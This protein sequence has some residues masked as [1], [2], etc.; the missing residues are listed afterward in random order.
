MDYSMTGCSGGRYPWQGLF[1]EQ[2]CGKWGWHVNNAVEW[3]EFKDST[4]RRIKMDIRQIDEE[5][6]SHMWKFECHKN[7]PTSPSHAYQQI[8]IAPFIVWCSHI[9]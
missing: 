6:I 9:A 1:C 5:K 3:S 7:T 2:L 4:F 8:K